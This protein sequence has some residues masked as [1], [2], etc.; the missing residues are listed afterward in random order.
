MV[1]PTVRLQQ[2][3][4]GTGISLD[5]GSDPSETC[6][7]TDTYEPMSFEPWA[8]GYMPYTDRSIFSGD[9]AEDQFLEP[10]SAHFVPEVY[11]KSAYVSN[12]P[13]AHQS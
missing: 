6:A 10:W 2:Q 1:D 9:L 4:D 13:V 8:A 5:S 7:L 3:C 12:Q 11:S